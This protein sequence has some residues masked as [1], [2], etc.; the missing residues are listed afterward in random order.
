MR[1][2]TCSTWNFNVGFF[3]RN[4]KILIIW[5]LYWILNDCCW[6]SVGVVTAVHG[7]SGKT[8]LQWHSSPGLRSPIDHGEFAPRTRANSPIIPS[9]RVHPVGF[10]LCQRKT[11]TY[12]A[13]LLTDYHLCESADVRWKVIKVSH[14]WFNRKFSL[15]T[16][17]DPSLLD[18]LLTKFVNSHFE[19]WWPSRVIKREQFYVKCSV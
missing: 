17:L 19:T 4:P 11:V 18:V 2:W 1:S 3:D 14:E 16:L 8:T 13:Q 12:L 9:H 10:S 5:C 15:R 7:A 6:K